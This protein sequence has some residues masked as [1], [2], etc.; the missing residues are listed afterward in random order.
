MNEEHIVEEEIKVDICRTM[1]TIY[2]RGL[3]SATGGNVSARIPGTNEFWITPHAIFKGELLTSDLVRISLEGNILE[4]SKKPSIEVPMHRAIYKKRPDVNAIVHA[5]NPVTLGLAL[6]GIEIQP[7]T[8]E[9]AFALG[10][11]PV[12]NFALPGT[13]ELG[14]AVAEHIVGVKALILQ[15]HGVVGV[16]SNLMEAE[17]IVEKLEEVSTAQWVACGLGKPLRIPRKYIERGKKLY[18][19][20]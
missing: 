4:G 3:I 19:A 5:H 15:N 12:A 17:A 10:K 16:G 20:S 7:V 6:I 14:N 2:R 13:D 8:V 1:A 18:Q 9:A 11:V